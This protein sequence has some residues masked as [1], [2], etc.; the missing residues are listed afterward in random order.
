MEG[1][2]TY[3]G[4]SHL[5]GPPHDLSQM[6]QTR[7]LTD[8]EKAH[9]ARCVGNLKRELERLDPTPAGYQPSS[10]DYLK[11]LAWVQYEG[12][13]LDPRILECDVVTAVLLFLAEHLQSTRNFT[14]LKWSDL[15]VL[16][17]QRFLGCAPLEMLGFRPLQPGEG[18]W[19]DE[20]DPIDRAC[21]AIELLDD[22]MGNLNRA[23][24]DKPLD[25]LRV[26]LGGP[27]LQM[28]D[29]RRH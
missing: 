4:P 22:A 9:I 28:L 29:R 10:E 3:E 21:Q 25:W 15:L 11:K 1:S 13:T 17:H 23:A 18:N 27:W 6:H 2:A 5:V 26:L 24:D 8:D 14:L 12:I 20:D 16:T 19:L 7:A